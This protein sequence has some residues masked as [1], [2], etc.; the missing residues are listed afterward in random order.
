M[1]T[2]ASRTRIVQIA[3]ALALAVLATMSLPMIA[4]ALAMSDR[5]KAMVQPALTAHLTAGH[6]RGCTTWATVIQDGGK[7]YNYS[8]NAASKRSS[9]SFSPALLRAA[10][11]SF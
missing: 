2:M 9:G 6:T 7:S 8:A 3:L 5:I 4:R 11:T 1:K 10:G